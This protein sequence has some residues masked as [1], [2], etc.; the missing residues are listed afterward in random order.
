MEER[1]CEHCR[2]VVLGK[3]FDPYD[4]IL[5]NRPVDRVVMKTLRDRVRDLQDENGG[6]R[7]AARATGID[8]GYLQRLKSGEKTNPSDDVLEKLGLQKEV[9]YVL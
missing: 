7:A 3:C 9:I 5:G 4:C 2:K 6:L 8:C 1:M